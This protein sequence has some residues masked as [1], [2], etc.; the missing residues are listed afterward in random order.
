MKIKTKKRRAVTSIGIVAI[1]AIMIGSVTAYDYAEAKKHNLTNDPKGANK[2]V[3]GEP[4]LNVIPDMASWQTI[5][6]GTIKTSTNSD[7]IITHFQECAI[8]TGLKLDIQNE[9]L[10]SVVRENVR[11]LI[12]DVVVPASFG[13]NA[14]DND[15]VDGTFGV[16]TMCSRAYSIDTNVLSTLNATCQ[17]GI[18][19]CP[20]D[21]FFD[22]YIRTK[23]THGWQW[24]VLNVGANNETTEH[25]VKIQ[26]RTFATIDGM[27]MGSEEAKNEASDSG[28][29]MEDGTERGCVDSILEVGKKV[30]IIEEDKLAVGAHLGTVE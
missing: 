25:T 26:A 5:I 23:Q 24:I 15:E 8:H 30:L 22:S 28:S 20:T 21:I 12:D 1:A 7:L 10:S 9:N 13:E 3:I 19:P 16:V 4:L 29:C 2:T 6:A 11:L 27:T 18:G 17:N 14:T